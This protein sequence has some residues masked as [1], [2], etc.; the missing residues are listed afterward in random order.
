MPFHVGATV[1]YYNKELLDKAGVNADNIKTWNDFTEAGKKVVAATGKPM[2]AFEVTNQRPFWPMI[3]QRGSDYL[4][5]NG[6]VIL[7]NET[8][9]KT[10]NAMKD[11]MYKDK[12]AIAM[13]GGDT[14]KEEFFSAL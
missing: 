3:V 14:T 7:D 6:N 12:I 1:V 10:L 2:T 8:N 4:D 9:I 11:M 5:K 13:P